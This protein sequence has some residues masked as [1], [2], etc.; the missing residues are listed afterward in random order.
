MAEQWISTHREKFEQGQE[1]IFALELRSDH[2]WIGAIDL[3][4]RPAHNRAEIGY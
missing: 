2:T 1:I 4:P 3:R